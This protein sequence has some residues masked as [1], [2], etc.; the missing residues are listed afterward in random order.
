MN[1]KLNLKKTIE[2]KIEKHKKICSETKFHGNW[3]KIKK[4]MKVLSFEHFQA[5]NCDLSGRGQ[6][7]Q[8]C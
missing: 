8:L 4:V 7:G 6:K 1:K 2:I 5:Q 3:L